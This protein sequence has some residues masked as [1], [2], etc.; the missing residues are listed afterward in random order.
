MHGGVNG[1][2]GNTGGG[3]PKYA[4]TNADEAPTIPPAA[5]PPDRYSDRYDDAPQKKLNVGHPKRQGTGLETIHDKMMDDEADDERENIDDSEDESSIQINSPL[6]RKENTSSEGED[7]QRRIP[8]SSKS[9]DEGARQRSADGDMDSETDEWERTYRSRL[10]DG[11]VPGKDHGAT[12]AAEAAKV[13][14]MAGA[15]VAKVAEAADG[16]G[17]DLGGMDGEDQDGMGGEDQGGMGCGDQGGMGGEDQGGMGGEDQ[18][19]MGGADQGGRGGE[20]QGGMGDEGQDG[21][22]TA[23]G[24]TAK[25]A[26]A[27][28]ASGT[29][30]TF[31][32]RPEKECCG[33]CLAG[34][35]SCTY[36]KKE[37]AAYEAWAKET[38]AACAEGSGPEVGVSGT[39]DWVETAGYGTGGSP[40][41]AYIST[42][43]PAEIAAEIEEGGS[44]D[45]KPAVPAKCD[46]CDSLIEIEVRAQDEGTFEKRCQDCREMLNETKGSG[47]DPEPKAAAAVPMDT[48]EAEA[49]G[50]TGAAGDGSTGAEKR[51]LKPPGRN[52]WRKLKKRI[53][54]GKSGGKV[55]RGNWGGNGGGGRRSE[56]RRVGSRRKRQKKFAGKRKGSGSAQKG[57]VPMRILLTNI[58]SKLYVT[59]KNGTP[60]RDRLV[61]ET[62]RTMADV[63]FMSETG[64]KTGKEIEIVTVEKDLG[65]PEQVVILSAGSGEGTNEEIL[66]EN[67]EPKREGVAVILRGKAKFGWTA[68]GERWDRVSGRIMWVDIHMGPNLGIVR[69]FIIYHPTAKNFVGAKRFWHELEHAI[70]KAEA[71]ESVKVWAAHGDWNSRMIIDQIPENQRGKYAEQDLI[72]DAPGVAENADQITSFIL[73]R[74]LAVL[75]T[76]HNETKPQT[77]TQLNNEGRE[78]L[79]EMTYDMTVMPKHVG[80]NKD[81]MSSS[82]V[83]KRYQFDYDSRGENADDHKVVETMWQMNW[84]R[85]DARKAANER[86]AQ[87]KGDQ[88]D[89]PKFRLPT[90]EWNKEQLAEYQD[91]MDAQ[92]PPSSLEGLQNIMK[93]VAT[94]V[95]PRDKMKV[96]QEPDITNDDTAEHTAA[97]KRRHEEASGESY[98]QRERRLEVNR[99]RRERIARKEMNRQR[100]SDNA[101]KKMSAKKK[102]DYLEGLYGE[103]AMFPNLPDVDQTLYTDVQESV[104]IKRLNLLFKPGIAFRNMRLR[105]F[106]QHVKSVL[107]KMKSKS[108]PGVDGVPANLFKKLSRRSRKAVVGL[109]ADFFEGKNVTGKDVRNV[110]VR[111][112]YKGEKRGKASNPK[113]YRT[114]GIPSCTRKL[115]GGVFNSFM[116]PVTKI[117]IHHSQTAFRADNECADGVSCAWHANEYANST[118]K[119]LYMILIDL[120]KGY[121]K[122]SRKTVLQ[123]LTATGLPKEMVNVV[124]RLNTGTAMVD[125]MTKGADGKNME[126]PTHHGVVQGCVISPLLWLYL[127]DYCRRYWRRDTAIGK[128]ETRGVKMTARVP[129]KT[130]PVKFVVSDRY[131]ADDIS[132]LDMD[133]ERGIETAESFLETVKYLTG[134]DASLGE[135]GKTIWTILGRAPALA[136]GEEHPQK[137][138]NGKKINFAPE[139]E[140]LG[141]KLAPNGKS[142]EVNVKMKKT[143]K[144]RGAFTRHPEILSPLAPEAYRIRRYYECI[145]GTWMHGSELWAP[146][147]QGLHESLSTCASGEDDIYKQ[148]DAA[149]AAGLK[150]V[151]RVK[152]TVEWDAS[153]LSTMNAAANARYAHHL[154]PSQNRSAKARGRRNALRAN[155]DLNLEKLSAITQRHRLRY[156]GHIVREGMRAT[157]QGRDIPHHCLAPFAAIG[158]V[159]IFD[160]GKEKYHECTKCN[161]AIWCSSAGSARCH[162][163]C[164]RRAQHDDSCTAHEAPAEDTKEGEGGGQAEQD[165]ETVST[166]RLTRGGAEALPPMRPGMTRRCQ[167]CLLQGAGP[168]EVTQHHSRH[169]GDCPRFQEEPQAEK[170]KRKRGGD[171]GGERDDAANGAGP[172]TAAKRQAGSRKQVVRPR[173]EDTTTRLP[174][175]HAV[176]ASVV[177]EGPRGTSTRIKRRWPW[178]AATINDL[179]MVGLTSPNMMPQFHNDQREKIT[180]DRTR[181]FLQ[182]V[183]N[184]VQWRKITLKAAQGNSYYVSQGRDGENN[185]VWKKSEA[186][187]ARD[188]DPQML[189]R[190]VE[191]EANRN[192][193]EQAYSA[194]KEDEATRRTIHKQFRRE[195]NAAVDR[196]KKAEALRRRAKQARTTGASTQNQD[197]FTSKEKM[198]KQKAVDEQLK[199]AAKAAK[200]EAAKLWTATLLAKKET[201]DREQA[202]KRQDEIRKLRAIKPPQNTTATSKMN[203][204]RRTIRERPTATSFFTDNHDDDGEDETTSSTGGAGVAAGG[205]RDNSG[206]ARGTKGTAA[207]VTMGKTA[208]TTGLGCG[209]GGANAGGKKRKESSSNNGTIISSSKRNKEKKKNGGDDGA[210]RVNSGKGE[211]GMKS[212]AERELEAGGKK[213]AGG[214]RKAALEDAAE[215]QQGA[216]GKGKGSSGG[217]GAGGGEGAGE[218]DGRDGQVQ[219]KN[220]R[221]N[222]RKNKQYTAQ[223]NAAHKE[224]KHRRR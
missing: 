180:A 166:A 8:E 107:K 84:S 204:S 79:A 178:L 16:A 45:Q 134:M 88:E 30:C 130:E 157:A 99:R 115:I 11:A 77:F 177:A 132:F 133:L 92:T 209:S 109:V 100:Q 131:Y 112:L 183:R 76:Q 126:I 46:Q 224:R 4:G 173:I 148:V 60:V 22:E 219:K 15:E 137:F 96:V 71:D 145:V 160:V 65:K 108:S 168:D 49:E 116:A 135:D 222:R 192:E 121:D 113:A 26:G 208:A 139:A 199:R 193:A 97:R 101:H 171:A 136:E 44:D 35:N 213:R 9:E 12:E 10:R 19:G 187:L 94:Q 37:V 196:R 75:H 58:N 93:A 221:K 184:K 167:H 179:R 164:R 39:G 152:Q 142:A 207:A 106:E 21:M 117:A 61:T 24:S 6:C 141:I 205:N 5:E 153:K 63:L 56:R 150:R 210:A 28:T 110:E 50:A 32:D 40:G 155:R 51:A 189:Q 169:A 203:K 128:D 122:V 223:Q 14:K 172:A 138:I 146:S 212:R 154:L 69:H 118:G 73:D 104:E 125:K 7:E 90:R 86:K 82:R 3:R 38:G 52:E 36:C 170:K 57:E 55:N 162:A 158:E 202:K 194:R 218:G 54:K 23:S 206:E 17:E 127:I 74:D 176:G 48:S 13:A 83:L 216:S 1:E 43:F 102:S 191:R 161:E 181:D 147:P 119:K 124:A 114:I 175:G 151:L 103:T 25:T 67:E 214:K 59:E 85:E 201:K 64:A 33:N 163:A 42:L 156:F 27:T 41:P 144:V 98:S 129:W 47:G 18:G 120:V 185:V 87:D 31:C 68:A 140:F 34:C 220:E 123:V 215:Q 95:F 66:W 198:R 149:F 89:P 165:Q 211:N 195:H 29:T 174:T 105:I 62:V 188:N 186:A 182:S 143:V 2:K 217:A 200:D 91:K 70:E 72:T 20:D 81:I 159:Y 111:W 53:D 78:T 197:W 190:R 80:A